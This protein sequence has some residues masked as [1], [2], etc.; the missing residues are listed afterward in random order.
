MNALLAVAALIAAAA[1]APAPAPASAKPG[2][3]ASIEEQRRW[4]TEDEVAPTV[5]PP[6]Y[7]V[8]IVEYMDY[9]CPY[10]RATHGPLKQL[11]A[12][13]KKVRVIFRDW[14]IFGPASEA[15][16][17]AAIAS[18]YQGKYL[19]M[20]DALM[21]TPLPL[22]HDKIKAAAVKAGVD[23]D[24]LQKDMAAH[25]EEIED[26]FQRND[27]QAQS[28]GLEGTPGFIIGEVQS[29]G[30]MTLKQLQASVAKARATRNAAGRSAAPV[31]K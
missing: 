2:E 3:Q 7:D 4:F 22:D 10:C 16:A 20:H 17:L 29:F 27:E 14:P 9:Q 13:D 15:A 25:S 19:A 6:G 31:A 11:L 30:G 12:K 28:I 23:W 1:T 5:K 18:K 24:R 26:L 8:T 21:E